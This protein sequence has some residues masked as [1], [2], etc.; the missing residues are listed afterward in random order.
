MLSREW[1][2][3]CSVRLPS[4]DGGSCPDNLF[5]RFANMAAITNLRDASVV[6]RSESR[7]DAHHSAGQVTSCR[8]HGLA[9][10]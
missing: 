5:E 6:G 2:P 7:R 9:Q 8:R 3:D 4:S 10:P 1:D